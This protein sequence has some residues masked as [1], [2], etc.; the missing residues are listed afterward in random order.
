MWA[1]FNP[2]FIAAAYKVNPLGQLNSG[3]MDMTWVHGLQGFR[4][5]LQALEVQ[6]KAQQGL[7]LTAPCIT[8]NKVG[9]LLRTKFSSHMIMSLLLLA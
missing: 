4:G 7:H 3:H 9:T 8:Q 2:P 6:V 1:L 5:R